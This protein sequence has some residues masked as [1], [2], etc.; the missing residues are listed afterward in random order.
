MKTSG[1]Q[2]NREEEQKPIAGKL[3]VGWGGGQVPD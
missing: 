3:M 1:T 2:T